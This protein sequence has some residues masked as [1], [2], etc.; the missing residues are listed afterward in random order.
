MGK[1][2]TNGFEGFFSTTGN[3][4]FALPR[5]KDMKVRTTV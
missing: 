5:E 2:K 3:G 1:V 4:D